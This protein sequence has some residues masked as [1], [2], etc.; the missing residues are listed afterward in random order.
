[1]PLS[2]QLHDTEASIHIRGHFNFSLHTDFHAACR[3]ILASSKVHCLEINL[4]DADYLDSSA[5]GMLLVLREQA[6]PRDIRLLITNARPALR[7]V[8][9][10][11]H[12]EKFFHID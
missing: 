2:Y 7:Q 12:F 10:I 9:A 3:A 1:M 5:L 4:Q 6:L 11:A 8:L